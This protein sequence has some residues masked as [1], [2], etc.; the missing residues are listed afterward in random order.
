MPNIVSHRRAGQVGSAES[1]VRSRNAG[2][3]AQLKQLLI[4]IVNVTLFSEFLADGLIGFA[5][6][7]FAEKFGAVLPSSPLVSFA[8]MVATGDPVTAWLSLLVTLAGSVLA[9]AVLY[10]LGQRADALRLWRSV[11]CFRLRISLL[12]RRLRRPRGLDRA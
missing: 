5:L 3:P 6:G 10:V 2:R 4:V 11:Q 8:G 7:A 9:T 12:F 1:R